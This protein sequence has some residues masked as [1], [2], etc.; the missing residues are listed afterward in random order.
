[1]NNYEVFIE[2]YEYKYD[3]LILTLTR[4]GMKY[5]IPFFVTINAYNNMRYRLTQNFSKKIALQLNNQDEYYNIFGNMRNKMQ[6]SIFGRG[7]ISI[8]EK[9]IFEFQTAKICEDTMYNESI[10][11]T[12]KML[13][14]EYQIHAEP[15]PI[16][17][18][19][20]D[21]KDIEKYVKDLSRCSNR[22][23]K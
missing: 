21:I 14:E 3:D 10:Q 13:N 1:M 4:E 15:I 20:V 9:S 17:P 22:Y 2:N 12:I 23:I 19:R 16:M 7:F 8:E 5:A 11:K 6:L 18:D